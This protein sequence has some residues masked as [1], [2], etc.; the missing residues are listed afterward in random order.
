MVAL[1]RNPIKNKSEQSTTR[2]LHEKLGY[3]S[4][5]LTSPQNAVGCHVGVVE[6]E[7]GRTGG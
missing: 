7:S 4:A 3:V 6:G 1:G 5:N 2:N